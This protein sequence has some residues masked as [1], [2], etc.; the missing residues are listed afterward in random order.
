MDAMAGES[1]FSETVGSS[2]VQADT[3]CDVQQRVGLSLRQII[4]LKGNRSWILFYELIS[5]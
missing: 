3:M 4:L 5:A 1:S 2:E